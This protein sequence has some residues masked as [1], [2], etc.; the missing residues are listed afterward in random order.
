MRDA[1]GLTVGSIG[2]VVDIAAVVDCRGAAGSTP[3]GGRGTRIAA[4]KDSLVG[5]TLPTMS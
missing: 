3:R 5:A 2:R 1:D 4:V